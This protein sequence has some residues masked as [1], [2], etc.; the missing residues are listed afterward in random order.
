MKINLFYYSGA[1]NTKFIAKKINEKL[2]SLSHEVNMMQISAKSITNYSQ[3][4]DAYII[5]F[6]V[7]D[8]SAPLLVQDLVNDLLKQNKPIAYFCTKA[9]LSVNAIKELHDISSNKGLQ[10]VA[11]L[12]LFM[13][14][15]DA[16][17]LFAKR[18]SKTERILKSFHS[19]HL[20]KKVRVF[21]DNFE[22][23]K[24]ISIS[25]KRY[26]YFGGLIPKKAKKA[27]HDQY[28]KYIP[29]F[30]SKSDVC[31]QCMLCV[32]GCPRDNIRFEDGIKFE[33]NCDMCLA[34]LH[35]CPVD[36]IQ[37]GA[38]TNGTVRLRK[39]EINDN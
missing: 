16:L 5:G 38:Y 21:I 7:Y 26:S 35:H 36:S 39:I 19:K 12:D 13:P 11:I 8:L 23:A 17:A 28:N 24:E 29:E 31:I 1:G 6:P 27:F 4:A 33:L 20:D 22:K 32:K 2:L 25:K 34:C 15:T 30:Y 10:T 14:A 3:Q 18:D 9:F 37:L